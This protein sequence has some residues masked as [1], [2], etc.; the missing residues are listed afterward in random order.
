MCAHVAVF[1][2]WVASQP[3][4][5]PSHCILVFLSI[6]SFIYCVTKTYASHVGCSCLRFTVCSNNICNKITAV[7]TS[8]SGLVVDHK[9]NEIIIVS[10]E[11]T[12]ELNG[13]HTITFT[14][15]HDRWLS[16]NISFFN[17]FRNRIKRMCV[18]VCVLCAYHHYEINLCI[19]SIIRILHLFE[20][21]MISTLRS[22][23]AVPSLSISLKEI[24]Y[25]WFLLDWK[26][27]SANAAGVVG[28][29]C[30]RSILDLENYGCKR[31]RTN[32]LVE[33]NGILR[34]GSV[35]F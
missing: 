24:T 16:I 30:H 21:A 2:Y 31:E 25:I 7:I 17:Q 1:G 12:N 5:Q 18:S 10:S 14:Q 23:L 32:E 27:T 34:N 29:H 8:G 9:W 4:I 15:S 3:A 13:N 33:V 35:R 19:Y 6:H 22:P 11:D 28:I 26:A 20:L